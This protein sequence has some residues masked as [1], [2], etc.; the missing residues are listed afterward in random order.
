MGEDESSLLGFFRESIGIFLLL[1]VKGFRV[2]LQKGNEIIIGNSG[3]E[4]SFHV[5]VHLRRRPR[6]RGGTLSTAREFF[7]SFSFSFLNVII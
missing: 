6:H 4:L 5:K 3:F 2:N 1:C 7:F